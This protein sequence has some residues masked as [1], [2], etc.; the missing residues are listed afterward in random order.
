MSS[1]FR[2]RAHRRNFFSRDDLRN[3]NRTFPAATLALGT[4]ASV[5]GIT[6]WRVNDVVAYDRM[7]ESAS[8]LTS[9]LLQS[10]SATTEER[11]GARTELAQLRHDLLS[12]DG[13]DRVAVGE[14]AARID[15]RIAELKGS[16]T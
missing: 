7:R 4:E 11:S 12:L 16:F 14:L 5:A 1:S 9:L 8:A 13:Y 2:T 3:S 10:S 6:A 15:N